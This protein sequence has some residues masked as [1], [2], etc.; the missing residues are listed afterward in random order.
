M[1]IESIQVGRPRTLRYHGHDVSTAILK[2]TV[3]G[4]VMVR[5]FNLDGDAQADLRV[6]GGKDKAVYAYALSVLEDWRRLRPHDVFVN[7]AMGENLSIDDFAESDIFIGDT[8]EVGEAILQVS[9]P[10]FPCKKLGVKFND[11]KIL[12]Q[13]ME[14]TRPGIYFRVLKEGLIEAGQE[15]RLIG[16]EQ[17]KL[18]VTEL[19]QLGDQDELDVQR[20]RAI[21][22]IASLPES[23]RSQIEELLHRG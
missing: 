4:P 22:S 3:T 10:R 23:W 5:T 18:S 12:R 17:T 19:F 2:T 15:L 7:G 11:M 16:Q 8:Y 9:Q 14:L 13:F 6:H 20:L 21:A 1:R